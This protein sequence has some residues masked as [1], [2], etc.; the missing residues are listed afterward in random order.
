MHCIESD[1]LLQTDPVLLLFSDNVQVPSLQIHL[2]S[3][4]S[5]P[6][7]QSLPALPS[8]ISLSPSLPPFSSLTLPSLFPPHV[9]Y[10]YFCLFICSI[11]TLLSI[12]I[13]P[14]SL[15]LTPSSLLAAVYHHYP[16][17]AV[18]SACLLAQ[19]CAN[20]PPCATP[21]TYAPC[22]GPS[23]LPW[24]RQDG[25]AAQPRG[26]DITGLLLWLLR[27]LWHPWGR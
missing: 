6:N 24:A 8:S 17:V 22:S 15:C 9:V 25:K 27:P 14:I 21:S 18:L 23:H 16:P 5:V 3:L 10:L 20:C 13:F 19:T 4:L 2:H 1:L 11:P 12:F 7:S 26:N